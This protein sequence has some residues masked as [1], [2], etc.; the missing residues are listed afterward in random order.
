M[1]EFIF[2]LEN[3]TLSRI[4]AFILVFIFHLSV[5]QEDMQQVFLLNTRG[6]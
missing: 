1:K 4:F 2:F 3:I 6:R 5:A